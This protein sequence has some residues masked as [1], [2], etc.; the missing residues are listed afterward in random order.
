MAMVVMIT[1]LYS[2]VVIRTILIADV[3]V[4]TLGAPACVAIVKK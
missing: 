3:H 2:R 4:P 1:H